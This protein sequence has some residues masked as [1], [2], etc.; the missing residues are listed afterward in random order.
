M[1]YRDDD[2]DRNEEQDDLVVQQIIKLLDKGLQDAL[3]I[4]MQNLF[5]DWK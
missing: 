3:T 5:N 4:A 2:E 1:L